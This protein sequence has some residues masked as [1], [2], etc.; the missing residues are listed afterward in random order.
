MEEKAKR[1]LEGKSIDEF[2]EEPIQNNSTVIQS[3]MT[4]EQF[5]SIIK[6]FINKKGDIYKVDF[7]REYNHLPSICQFAKIFKNDKKAPEKF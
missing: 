6:D 7:G 4:K 2:E 3:Q 5:D 1:F